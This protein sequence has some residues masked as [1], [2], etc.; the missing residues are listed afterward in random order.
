MNTLN[1][2]PFPES[3]WVIPDLFLAGQ[4][5]AG[6][7]EL[8]TRRRLQTLIRTGLTSYIDLTHPN[9]YMP[10]YSDILQDEANGYLKQVS[11]TNFPIPD[12]S[13]VP[14]NQMIQILDQIDVNIN[15]NAPVYLHCIAGIGR[16]G[17]VVGCYLVRHGLDAKEVLQKIKQ[18]RWAVP[19]H[20]ARS[21]EA[22]EQ[23][24]F[25]MAWK[26]GQ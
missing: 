4:Y 8:D 18:L 7:D 16:T 21:P 11:Y 1:Q 12:R 17:T 23:V 15:K 10:R 9:D 2:I 22:D 25:I 19:S 26:P 3:Y 13:V 14:V 5:P 24:D 20:W 6:Y